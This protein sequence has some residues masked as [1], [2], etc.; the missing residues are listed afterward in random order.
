MSRILAIA[1]T[2]YM[3]LTLIQMKETVLQNDTVDILLSDASADSERVFRNLQKT[4]IFHNCFYYNIEDVGWTK[5]ANVIK[6]AGKFL[7]GAFSHNLIQK[8]GISSQYDIL[9]VYVADRFEE[10]IIF[11]ALKKNNPKILCELYEE[12]YV[13]YF[14]KFGF[15]TVYGKRYLKYVTKF[16]TLIGKK[17][18]LIENNINRAWFFNP[19]M[20]QYERDFETCAIPKLNSKNGQTTRLMNQVFGYSGKLCVNQRIIFLEGSS[21]TDGHQIDDIEILASIAEKIGAG[22]IAV[23]LHPRTRI[24]RFRELGYNTELEN[25]PLELVALNGGSDGKIFIAVESGAPIS[26]LVNFESDNRAL[27]LH[28]CSKFDIAL[29]QVPEFSEYLR[30]AA[31]QCGANKLFIP[32]NEKELFQCVEKLK[33]EV[34]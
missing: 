6:K 4:E 14:D 22:N 8:L 16:M 29:T 2:Y 31:S 25:I 26:C 12:G 21:Y 17:S 18:W 33:E 1:H 34:L 28:K 7:K 11:N 10:Q 27:L 30:I 3:L 24:N 13:S 15:F 19:E 32:E 5:T 20:V 9:L 23:K